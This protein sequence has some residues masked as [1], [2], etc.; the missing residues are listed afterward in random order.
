MYRHPENAARS[1]NKT[2]GELRPRADRNSARL[3]A[4][5]AKLRGPDGFGEGMKREEI[6]AGMREVTMHKRLPTLAALGNVAAFTAL[7]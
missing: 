3:K 1:W 5:L 2:P 4:G 7:D 6:I